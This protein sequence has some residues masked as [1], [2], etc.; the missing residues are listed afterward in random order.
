MLLPPPVLPTELL[1]PTLCT[2]ELL[3]LLRGLEGTVVTVVEAV[4][5]A[6]AVAEW[7]EGR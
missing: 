1:L 7:E 2:E 6:A 5:A 4:V 3:L